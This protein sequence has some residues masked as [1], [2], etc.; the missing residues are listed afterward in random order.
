M[1]ADFCFRMDDPN[2]RIQDRETDVQAMPPGVPGLSTPV[3]TET[4]V[5]AMPPGVPGLSTPE[6]TEIAAQ[7]QPS[8]VAGMSTPGAT[9]IVG[10]A[11]PPGVPGLSTPG[12]QMMQDGV[13]QAEAFATCPFLSLECCLGTCVR[14]TRLQRGACQRFFVVYLEE[15]EEHFELVPLGMPVEMQFFQLFVQTLVQAF[16]LQPTVAGPVG[17]VSCMGPWVDRQPTSAA[18]QIEDRDVELFGVVPSGMPSVQAP[19]G[20]A[21]SPQPPRSR[22]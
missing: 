13:G 9:V 19:V 18:F 11:M 6:A 17:G 14:S 20:V 16:P 4:D 22:W 15:M 2:H 7:M 1:G 12:A 5:Q 10:Q 3:A 21:P 8:G